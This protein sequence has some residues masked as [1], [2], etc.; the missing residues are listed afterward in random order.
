[1][2]IGYVDYTFKHF[3]GKTTQVRNESLRL[4]SRREEAKNIYILFCQF[5]KKYFKFVCP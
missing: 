5:T 2:P 3:V 1:M 4:C